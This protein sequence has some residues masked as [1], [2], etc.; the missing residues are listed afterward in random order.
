MQD[1]TSVLLATAAANVSA[2]HPEAAGLAR[3][4][5]R[6]HCESA[7]AEPWPQP[8][9][10]FLGPLLIRRGYFEI[11]GSGGCFGGGESGVALR[12]RRWWHP[13]I[14]TAKI[15]FLRRTLPNYKGGCANPTCLGRGVAD[16]Q[17]YFT[18]SK[19][20]QKVI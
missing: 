4:K 8:F 3:T 7:A 14:E 11:S 2:H 15:N 5:R 19:I 13:A 20:A 10:L 1:Y 18:N 6:R 12:L 16:F 17:L 9:G